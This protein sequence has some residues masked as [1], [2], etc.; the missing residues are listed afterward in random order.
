MLISLPWSLGLILALPPTTTTSSFHGPYSPENAISDA[1][2]SLPMTN[3]ELRSAAI[4][5]KREGFL[6][7]PSICGNVSYWP[8]G[9]LGNLT[10]KRDFA[11]LTVDLQYIQA[12]VKVDVTAVKGTIA[13]SG[14]P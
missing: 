10:T 13:V 1:P 9:P 3:S 14:S 5:D 4:L 11:R 6:Y 8:T 2:Y 12:A 7:G